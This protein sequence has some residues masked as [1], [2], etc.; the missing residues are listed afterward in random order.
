MFRVSLLFILSLRISFLKRI[1]T[2][3]YPVFNVQMNVLCLL[4]SLSNLCRQN[5]SPSFSVQNLFFSS[6]LSLIVHVLSFF[7]SFFLSG[8]RSFFLL[9]LYFLSLSPSLSLWHPSNSFPL[10]SFPQVSTVEAALLSPLLFLVECT[11]TRTTTARTVVFVLFVSDR[12]LV[13]SPLLFLHFTSFR[14]NQCTT[15]SLPN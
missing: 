15:T 8:R 5:K 9:P 13:F 12:S 1:L 10:C 6:D 14:V 2:L 11:L 7:L 3:R 4:W